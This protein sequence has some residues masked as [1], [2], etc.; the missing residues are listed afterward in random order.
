MKVWC[1][2]CFL[3]CSRNDNPLKIW[4]K[5]V[6]IV[7]L[8]LASL[9]GGNVGLALMFAD[10]SSICYQTVW[11]GTCYWDAFPLTFLFLTPLYA[12]AATFVVAWRNSRNMWEESYNEARGLHR[13]IDH[14]SFP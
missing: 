5:W 1:R 11:F 10:D 9:I 6:I 8:Y 2:A 7:V 14:D 4:L 13:L 12:F 3:F